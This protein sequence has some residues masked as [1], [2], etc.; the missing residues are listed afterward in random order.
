M[1]KYE[2]KYIGST[3]YEKCYYNQHWEYRGHQYIV[4]VPTGWNGSSDYYYGGYMS[5]KKQH[6][7]EQAAIDAMIDNPQEE[8]KT[9]SRN[10]AD[11]GFDLFWNYV[12]GEG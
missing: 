7:R 5:Q 6:E 10:E 1:K 12:N 3:P 4:T 11:E 8:P 2:A 9:V